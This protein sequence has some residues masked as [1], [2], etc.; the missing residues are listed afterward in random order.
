[1]IRLALF[2]LWLL[3]F[4]PLPVLR[5]L[6]AAFGLL[7]YLFGR[8]RR[9]VARIN[10]RL[11]FP[12]LDRHALRRLVRRHF[13]AFG[14][15]F[16]D[17]SLLWHASPARLQRLI[18][19]KGELPPSDQTTILLAPHFVGLDAGW[20][21]LTLDRP[22]LS[23]YANQKNP[24]INAAFY[25]GRTRFNAPLLLSRQEGMRRVVKALREM[26]S[27]YYLPDMDFGPRDA[28]FT[29]FFGVPAATITALPRL[30]RMADAAVVPCVTRMTASGYE[31]EL[32]PAWADY[33]SDDTQ[34]DTR[35][36][37]AFIEEQVGHMPE[38]YFWVHKRFKTRPP[39]E[40]K[41]Y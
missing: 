9:R 7:L 34:A 41:F 26:S 2:L 5:L 13:I 17:R 40:A 1:M 11:C 39:G 14:R 24:T 22:M 27:F 31:V 33:P 29:P 15:A 38:Q 23:I 8:E 36:V 6:G 28:I 19:L 32:L 21:L 10:L 25:A 16:V 30:A 3:H 37:N 18:T 35:R 20:M 4:L 12:Q